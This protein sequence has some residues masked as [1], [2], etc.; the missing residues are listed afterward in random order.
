MERVIPEWTKGLGHEIATHK[1]QVRCPMIVVGIEAD[2]IRAEVD[3]EP[4][5]R[6]PEAG[7]P[8]STPLHGE[9]L[10][11]ARLLNLNIAA[12]AIAPQCRSAAPL[13]GHAESAPI[14]IRL[15]DI[16]GRPVAGAL[17]GTGFVRDADREPSYTP[18]EGAEATISDQRGEA[19]LTLRERMGIYAIRP[20][21]DRPLVGVHEVAREESGKPI[22]IVM[23]PACRVRLRVEC[24]GFRDLEKKYHVALS[25]PNWLRWASVKVGDIARPSNLLRTSSMAGE[26]EVLLPPGRYSILVYSSGTK[27][28]VQPV[29]IHPGHRLRNLGIIEVAPS[30]EVRQGI[31]HGFWRSRAPLGQHLFDGEDDARRELF[32]RP[33]WGPTL[34]AGPTRFQDI[35]FSADG[36]TLA[37]AQGLS[38]AAGDVRLWDVRNGALVAT[39]P[40]PHGVDGVHGLA[41]SP[42]GE[43]LAG[44]VTSPADLKSPWGIALW[45]LEG[46]TVRRTVRGQ[47]VRITTL[48]FS[49]DGKTLASG[50][51]DRSVHF[52]DVASGIET[53][54][55]EKCPSWVWSLAYVPDGKTLVIGSSDT[56]KLW[57]IPGDRLRATL[58][59][60]GFSVESIVVSPDGRTLAAAGSA[61]SPWNRTQQ[62]QIRLY[63]IAQAPPA[64]RLVLVHDLDADHKA[65]RGQDV[66]SDVAFTP[67][68]DRVVAVVKS[69]IVIWDAGTGVELECPER[70]TGSSTDRLAL[71]SDGRWLAVT[72]Y[73]RARLLEMPG[74]RK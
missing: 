73:E 42:G 24:P 13:A 31:F 20:D 27:P 46:R 14:R 32:R 18:D 11:V 53:S 59:S 25:G 68:G 22:T 2:A 61:G 69:A 71:S 23:H 45:D 16:Q 9:M 50:G 4:S 12:V 34:L 70:V 26:L 54:R 35:A 43:F 8:A 5:I 41:F 66:F 64:R 21:K 33:R 40:V 74:L 1:V 17:V 36:D 55:I 44:T 63:D 7:G 30:W 65:N 37:T 47:S 60:D 62:G 72:E 10:E 19:S 56:L 52:C 49:P 58:E 51:A 39:L 57:D 48:A 38:V 3:L 6:H 28:S 67:G 15:V 29:E